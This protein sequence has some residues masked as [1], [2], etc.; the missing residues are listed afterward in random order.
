MIV[1]RPPSAGR[2]SCHH[3]SRPAMAGKATDTAP[4][5][6]SAALMGDFQVP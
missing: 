3:T 5:A 6:T 4:L 1:D 2:R